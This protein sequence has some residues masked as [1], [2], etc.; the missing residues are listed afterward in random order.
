MS[1]WNKQT[2]EQKRATLKLMSDISNDA[3]DL[4]D[5]ISIETA[6]RELLAEATSLIYVTLD[7]KDREQLRDIRLIKNQ[8]NQSI[9]TRLSE[10]QK[11]VAKLKPK[12]LTVQSK[13]NRLIS[14]IKGS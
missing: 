14:L 4:K 13:I 9:L 1:L 8:I 3:E 2:K 5:K 10:K 12:G 7:N 6:K 11:E